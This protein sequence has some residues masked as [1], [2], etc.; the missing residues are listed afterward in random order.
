[1]PY[2]CH[3]VAAST[4]V[5]QIKATLINLQCQ[6]HLSSDTPDLT[7]YRQSIQHTH[8]GVQVHSQHL[9]LVSTLLQFEAQ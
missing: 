5:N 7:P 1:M 2:L 9:A 8:L 4:V 3:R 6:A